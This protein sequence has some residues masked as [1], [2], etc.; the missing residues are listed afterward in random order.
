MGEIVN[1][2]KVRKAKARAEQATVAAENRVRHEP[3]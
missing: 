3:S 1:L 2:R